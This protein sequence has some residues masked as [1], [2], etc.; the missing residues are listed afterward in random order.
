M[1][2]NGNVVPHQTLRLLKVEELNSK[3]EIRYTAGIINPNI[4]LS[5]PAEALQFDTALCRLLW[6]LVRANPNLGPVR[7]QKNDLADAYMRA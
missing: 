7:I 3:T 1:K 6:R 4:H 5:T 2:G